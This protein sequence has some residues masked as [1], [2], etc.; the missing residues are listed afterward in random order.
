MKY[1]LKL[2]W[3]CGALVGLPAGIFIALSLVKALAQ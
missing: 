1:K 3:L 2:D